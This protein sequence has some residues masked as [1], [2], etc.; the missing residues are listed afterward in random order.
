MGNFFFWNSKLFSN[1]VDIMFYSSVLI[2][3]SPIHYSLY[4]SMNCPDKHL[5]EYIWRFC[6]VSHE[7]LLQLFNSNLVL[8]SINIIMCKTAIIHALIMLILVDL[9]LARFTEVPRKPSKLF[10]HLSSSF[11]FW[12]FRLSAPPTRP[13]HFH[14]Q[15]DLKKYI[16]KVII[17]ICFISCF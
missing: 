2:W 14:S 16:Q 17:T 11:T 5:E 9:V 15:E 12:I 3:N 8:D 13:K 1:Y 4:W 10:Y 7:H 6:S